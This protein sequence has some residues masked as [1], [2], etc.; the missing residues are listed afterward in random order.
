L[1]KILLLLLFPLSLIAS[2]Y[3][4]EGYHYIAEFYQCDNLR[5]H[6]F[7]RKTF[8]FAA[9][10]SGVHIL[11]INEHVFENGGYSCVLTLSESHASIHTYPEYKAC[12]IDVF[13][14]GSTRELM[15]FVFYLNL[16][17]DPKHLGEM[18]LTRGSEKYSLPE[19]EE[20][21]N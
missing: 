18:Y 16:I 6:H 11:S 19:T 1:K 14:C 12:F 9:S 3:K 13:T 2:E 4:F 5:D 10:I 15:K 20:S 8:E 7:V 21:A 17:L